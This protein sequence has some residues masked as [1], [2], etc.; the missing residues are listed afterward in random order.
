MKIL[1]EQKCIHEA[2]SNIISQALSSKTVSR[3]EIHEMKEYDN[4]NQMG[5]INHETFYYSLKQLGDTLGL[6]NQKF[7]E[8]NPYPIYCNFVVNQKE[9]MGLRIQKEV[10]DQ[11]ISDL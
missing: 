7:M 6:Q 8:A 5:V 10:L 3:N 2:G 11:E 4:K 9:D 1:L